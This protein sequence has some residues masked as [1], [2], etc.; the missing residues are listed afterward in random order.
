MAILRVWEGFSSMG[1][2]I[3]AVIGVTVF[4]RWIRPRDAWRHADVITYGFPFGWIFGR[5]GC[6]VV[7]DHVGAPTSFFLGMH[8][9]DRA[10]CTTRAGP[11]EPCTAWAPAGPRHELGLYEALLTVGIAYLFYRLGRKDRP[12]GYFLAVWALAYAPVRFLLDFLR[13]TDLYHHDARY[14]GLTPG[15]YSAL[16][17]L[18]LGV[19]LWRSIDFRNFRPWPMDGQP[20]QASRALPSIADTADPAAPR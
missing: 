14:L 5:L 8:F 3:G 4:Y 13:N 18:V 15:H 6:F 9:P 12:P 7:H 19:W 20:D 10:L 1:G 2:F 17:M 16:F 11:E